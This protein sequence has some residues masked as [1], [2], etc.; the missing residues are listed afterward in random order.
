MYRLVFSQKY[1]IS[2]LNISGVFMIIFQDKISIPKVF[3]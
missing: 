3:F 2:Y 1:E